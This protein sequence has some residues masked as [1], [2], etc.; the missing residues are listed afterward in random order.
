VRGLDLALGPSSLLRL[1]TWV[2]PVVIL[3]VIWARRAAPD[4]RRGTL[5][6]LSVWYLVAVAAIKL[7]PTSPSARWA[8]WAFPVVAAVAFGGIFWLGW[9]YLGG[10]VGRLTLW[11]LAATATLGLALIFLLLG[12]GPSLTSTFG[13]L[14]F[15]ALPLVAVALF[16][17]LLRPRA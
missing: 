13:A 15:F 5:V 2:L 1:V 11:R 3:L 4:H 14:A 8:R 9:R 6:A 10:R 17:F 7:L 12:S 16:V